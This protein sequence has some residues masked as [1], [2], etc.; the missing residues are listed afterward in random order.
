MM[1]IDVRTATIADANFIVEFNRRLAQETESK[2]LNVARLEPGVRRLLEDPTLGRY[3]LA[4]APDG[5]VAGQIMH[6][7]EWSD[8]RNGRFWWI[9]SVY[10]ASEFRG[11]GVFSALYGHLRALAEREPDVVGLRLYVER[12][13]DRARRVYE[14]LGMRDTGYEVL[15]AGLD[16]KE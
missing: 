10:V 11:A 16:G 9:Q 3:F 15:E 8:W 4:V 6:T 5:A 12:G 7:E 14:K 2:T 13:N 1:A